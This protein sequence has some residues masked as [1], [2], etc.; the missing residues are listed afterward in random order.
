MHF[1]LL[2]SSCRVVEVF[3]SAVGR[4]KIYGQVSVCVCVKQRKV[5]EQLLYSI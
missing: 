5:G 4:V 3:G 2:R 1:S